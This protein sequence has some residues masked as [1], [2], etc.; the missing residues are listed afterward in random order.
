MGDKNEKSIRI[1]RFIAM[2]GVCARRRAD[3][4]IKGGEIKIN[5]IVVTNLGYQVLS[6]DFVSFKGGVISPEK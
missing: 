5:N 4:L 3:E 1:N 2:C 6:K